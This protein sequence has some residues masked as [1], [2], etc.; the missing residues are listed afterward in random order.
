MVLWLPPAAPP[1]LALLL[2]SLFVSRMHCGDLSI[3]L[4]KFKP[5]ALHICYYI[6]VAAACGARVRPCV[7]PGTGTFEIRPFS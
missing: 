5:S 3:K 2:F 1:S 6:C 7:H 4:W